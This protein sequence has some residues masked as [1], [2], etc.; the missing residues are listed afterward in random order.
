[1]RHYNKLMLP[2]A[3]LALLA[4]TLLP[5]RQNKNSHDA[6]VARNLNTFSSIVREVEALY[7]DTINV[8]KIFRA[9]IDSY[10][11][12]IDPYTTYFTEEE[13]EE[14]STMTYGEYAGIGSY[15]QQIDNYVTLSGVHKNSPAELA[16]LKTGDQILKI[17]TIDAKGFSTDDAKKRLMGP[18]G[19]DVNLTVL[20]PYNGADSVISVTVKR[21]KMVIPSVSY[22]TV[23]PQGIGYIRLTSFMDKS[24]AEVRSAAEEMKANPNLKGIVLDLRGNGGG[25]LESA[26]DI[27]NLF[28]DKGVEVIRTK[29]RDKSSEKIYKTTK[30]ALLPSTP[31]AVL[32]DG[33]SASASEITAGA[34]QDLDRAVLLGSNSYGKGLVQTVRPLP[35]GAMVKITTS[36]Y[37]IP[38]GRLIQALDYTNRNE[39]GSPG[40]TPDSLANS[41]KTLHGRTVKDG[42]GLKPDIEIE[43]MKPSRLVYNL[44]NDNWIF[45]YATKYAASHPQAPDID[46]FEITDSIYADFKAFIDPEKLHYDKVCDQVIKSLR[47]NAKLEGYMTDE[48]SAQI[49][50]LALALTHDLDHDLDIKRDDISSLL[51]P[52]IVSRYYYTEGSAAQ[53]LKHDEG[54]E[55]ASEILLDPARYHK[56]LNP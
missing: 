12:E 48:V 26:V 19:T 43:W 39:D 4:P 52:E 35:Y 21:K 16:G 30:S 14:F 32:I 33:G 28:V 34:L 53:D 44:V 22:S 29:G 5:A 54:F 37:Y 31:L 27:V 2:V 7:V 40:I 47:E 45:N 49:D 13:S 11:D 3:A 15:I 25:L 8:D 10:L 51:G 24:A 50:S 56:I 41:F 9:A 17:D 42:G 55:K 23:T 38:S 18:A 6:A 20:R 46:S 36:R 1:M